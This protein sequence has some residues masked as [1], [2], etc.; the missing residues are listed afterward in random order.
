M[1]ITIVFFHARTDQSQA[2]IRCHVLSLLPGDCAVIFDLDRGRRTPLAKTWLSRVA[3]PPRAR[4][5]DSG[6]VS[7]SFFCQCAIVR[8]RLRPPWC[9]ASRAQIR[10]SRSIFRYSAGF[11][12]RILTPGCVAT[13]AL[14]LAAS[15]G[16]WWE[17]LCFALRALSTEAKYLFYLY[18]MCHF[19][20]T[21]EVCQTVDP[22]N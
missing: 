15:G 19:K 4:R 13:L 9:H 20:L 8:A 5:R 6:V 22:R 1:R 16:S 7:S 2:A 3:S 18:R 21:L 14:A 11:S 12:S 17:F 10:T